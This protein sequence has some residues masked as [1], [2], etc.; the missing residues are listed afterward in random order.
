MATQETSKQQATG[1][2]SRCHKFS[3]MDTFFS[4]VRLAQS[5]GY[6]ATPENGAEELKDA[7]EEV[8]IQE[9]AL[10]PARDI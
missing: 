3:S 9:V 6:R 7:D 1:G 10:H 4:S 5:T 2:G 8:D